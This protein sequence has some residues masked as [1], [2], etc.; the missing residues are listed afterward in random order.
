MGN[1][2]SATINRSSPAQTQSPCQNS[3]PFASTRGATTFFF[4]YSGWL[5]P[6]LLDNT[7]EV[8]GL[9]DG[10]KDMQLASRQKRRTASFRTADIVEVFWLALIPMSE[11]CEIP[12]EMSCT[13]LHKLNTQFLSIWWRHGSKRRLL[14]EW[15]MKKLTGK[16]SR[17]KFQGVSESILRSCTGVHCACQST[18]CTQRTIYN[19]YKNEVWIWNF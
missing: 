9:K 10:E 18:Y 5:L 19:I 2:W 8:A 16:A 12:R 6:I 7:S 3:F 11:S 4:A 1:L 15:R 13:K 17:S 14:K